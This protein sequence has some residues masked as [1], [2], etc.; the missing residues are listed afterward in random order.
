[1]K[2]QTTLAAQDQANVA[3]L[4]AEVRRLR[5]RA[6]PPCFYTAHIGRSACTPRSNKHGRITCAAGSGTNAAAAGG[7]RQARGGG[8]RRACARP[9]LRCHDATVMVWATQH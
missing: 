5:P 7:V 8:A 1:M 6:Q 9:L 4:Q 2:A 3:V